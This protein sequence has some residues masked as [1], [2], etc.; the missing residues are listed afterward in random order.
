MTDLNQVI[1]ECAELIKILCK[2]RRFG[3]FSYHPRY[4]EK[5]NIDRVQEEMLDVEEAIEKLRKEVSVICGG[6][7]EEYESW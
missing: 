7:R 3:W 4:P 6:T 2:V 5:L 1:E